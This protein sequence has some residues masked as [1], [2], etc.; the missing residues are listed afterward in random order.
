MSDGG[1]FHGSAH[2]E[3][4]PARRAGGLRAKVLGVVALLAIVAASAAALG[5]S[6]LSAYHGRVEQMIRTSDTALLGERMDKLV[7][8]VVMDSRGIYMSADRKEAE[9]YAAPL[10]KNLAKL[11]DFTARWLALAPPE[12]AAR[13]KAAADKVDEFV[14]FRSELVRLAREQTLPEARAYGDN[15][16]NR[17]NRSQLNNLLSALVDENGSAVARA[18]N[19]LQDF[20]RERTWLLVV[21]SLAGIGAGVLLALFVVGK[22]VVRPLRSI[23]GAVSAVA[24]GHLETEVPG[25]SRKDEIGELARALASFKEKLRA[26]QEQERSLAEMRANNEKETARQLMEMCEM[27]EADL[28]SAVSEVLS[29]SADASARGTE[30]A[31]AAS[32]IASEAVAIAGA[33]EQASANVASVSA[34]AEELTATGKEMARRA[35]DMAEAAKKASVEA[36]QASATVAALSDAAES[37]GAI[38]NTI[39]EVASQTNLLALNATIEAARA[40][41]M[42]KGFAVVAHEVK[43]LARKTSEA[44]EDISKRISQICSATEESVGVIKKVGGSVNE[45]DGLTTAMAAAAEEQ[46]ATLREVARS[47]SEASSGVSAV[48]ASVTQISMRSTDIDAQSRQVSELVNGTNGRVSELR[49]NLVVSLRSSHAGDRRSSEYRRPV[50]MAGRLRCEG[51]V[52]EG[53]V[54]DVSEGGLRF[55]TTGSARSLAEGS[56]VIIETREFGAVE[57][58]IT[59]VGSTSVHLRFQRM[60]EDRRRALEAYLRSVDESDTVLVKAARTAAERIGTAFEAAIAEGRASEQQLFEFRYR[61]MSGTDPEQFETPFT[62]LCDAVLPEI[63]EPMLKI[64]HRIVFC[65]AVDRNG[66]LPTH[67]RQYAHPQRAGDAAWNAA[68]SRHRRFYKDRAGMAAAR[69]TREFLIQSYERQMGEGVTVLLK[70]VDVPVKINGKHWGGL[71]LAFKA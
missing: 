46:E 68:N 23:V 6:T 60:G 49:A 18:N 19:S 30:A 26:Q 56:A 1:S 15:D 11:Q 35:I 24:D 34:A 53:L 38:V 3:S 14:R 71:R 32:A 31:S 28:D 8:A 39:A 58:S 70:E 10:L 69:T 66:Y 57:A 47:L 51:R 27:L 25:L 54:L 20:F 43:A 48:A 12:E 55:K 41:E 64:D 9:K 65:A 45:M 40:G 33:S 61:P 7:T 42:G 16:A 4:R 63:Q 67:N 37:V 36:S 21:L 50:S 52:H 5:Y 62:A 44:A 2:G 22:S 29:M 17:A 59:A 13:Y